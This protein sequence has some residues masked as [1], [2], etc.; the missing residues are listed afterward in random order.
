MTD[1]NDRERAN[2]MAAEYKKANTDEE[3]AGIQREVGR[4]PSEQRA[5]FKTLVD[6]PGPTKAAA[7]TPKPVTAMVD[8]AAGAAFKPDPALEAK[9]QAEATEMSDPKINRMQFSPDVKAYMAKKKA[10]EDAAADKANAA[11]SDATLA[12]QKAQ[13]LA[14]GY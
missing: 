2:I 1:W 11:R 3:R 13:R 10:S 6:V 9:Q 7:E 5:K 12:K 4:L 8:A 14:R